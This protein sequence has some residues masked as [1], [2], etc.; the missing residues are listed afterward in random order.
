MTSK[1][2]GIPDTAGIADPA[3]VAVLDAVVDNIEQI[4]GRRGTRI[5]KLGATATTSGIIQKINEIIDRL[6]T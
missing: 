1:K 5:T 2:S 4:T 3:T 6:Q